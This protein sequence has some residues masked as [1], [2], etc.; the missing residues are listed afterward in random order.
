ME[1]EFS[2][3]QTLISLGLTA[4]QAK[5]YLTLAENG[6][7]ITSEIAQIAKIDRADIYRAITKLQQQG[8][9]ETIIQQ[10]IKIK[11]TPLNQALSHLMDK[12]TE[13]YKEV[14]SAIQMWLDKAAEEKQ[15]EDAMAEQPQFILLSHGK[16]VIKRISEAIERACQSVD[17]VLSWKRF[18]HGTVHA[19]AESM[20]AAWQKNV[21]FRFLIEQA[22]K[23][24][25]AKQLI[26]HCRQ[27]PLCQIRFI[28]HHPRTIFGIYDKKE[29]FIILFPDKDLPGSPALWSTSRSLIALA[30][31]YFD[32]LW[33][34]ATEN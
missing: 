31:D 29:I 32:M 30:K 33:A 2:K 8:L 9:I 19:F 18:T 27:K 4:K 3:I 16:Q 25:T 13:E 20:E 28:S 22:P 11:A 6:P 5:I 24:K 17:V 14:K 1:S 7:L 10:P 12:K 15:N 26:Q 23:S 34:A 21:R